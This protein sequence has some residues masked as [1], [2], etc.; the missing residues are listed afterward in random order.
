M[1]GR[2][3][4]P[5][6]GAAAR[7]SRATAAASCSTKAC[8]WR[9]LAERRR[10]PDRAS[11]RARHK[12][13]SPP[14]CCGRAHGSASARWRGRAARGNGRRADKRAHGR[15][16]PARWRRRCR[17]D[18][19]R[20]AS[21]RAPRGRPGASQAREQIVGEEPQR[22]AREHVRHRILAPGRGIG[23]D[24]MDHGVD[25]GRGGDVRAAGR[26]SARDRA[27]PSRRRAAGLLTPRFSR[28][29]RR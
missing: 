19:R 29:R 21:C 12:A 20:A 4:R 28:R 16:R 2:R 3:C 11:R 24:R 17:R 15:R 10:A 18:G 25:A 13:A 26:G 5:R 8:A 9:L 23:L 6:R 1:L 27:P 7:R 22:L 14:A